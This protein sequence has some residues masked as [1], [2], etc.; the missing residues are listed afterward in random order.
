MFVLGQIISHLFL[1][2]SCEKG[3]RLGY[4]GHLI[5]IFY[6]VVNYV[7]ESETLGALIENNLTESEDEQWTLIIHGEFSIAKQTQER[8]LANCNVN[9][10][11]DM[12]ASL[13]REIY[14][15][16][17]NSFYVNVKPFVLS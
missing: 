5:R 10:S 15:K 4:M 12:N 2:R 7:N 3:R 13:P 9:D 8:H 11:S 14:E 16:S 6:H 17:E 1:H